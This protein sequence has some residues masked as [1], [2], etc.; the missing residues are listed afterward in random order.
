MLRYTAGTSAAP[1]LCLLRKDIF[2]S[3]AVKLVSA[4]PL[5]SGIQNPYSSQTALW[6]SAPPVPASPSS[7]SPGA[8][9]TDP[10]A[11]PPCLAAFAATSSRLRARREKPRDASVSA[12]DMSPKALRT[13]VAAWAP[14]AACA[15]SS[16]PAPA[17]DASSTPFPAST[18][19]SAPASLSTAPASWSAGPSRPAS[20]VTSP[21][22]SSS[23]I[24]GGAGATF[25]DEIDCPAPTACE[26]A[27]E[28]TAR[29]PL[30][31]RDAPVAGIPTDATA[32]RS[33][34]EGASVG[35]RPRLRPP[36]VSN[37]CSAPG[38]LERPALST[39]ASVAVCCTTC[40][41]APGPAAAL[42]RLRPVSRVATEPASENSP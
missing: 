3:L 21:G 7:P 9:S 40:G 16:A 29:D 20:G 42:N 19:S 35:S 11:L 4:P 28:S 10:S 34:G 6:G 5:T 13:A 27:R 1:S 36:G 37:P 23:G 22:A 18:A 24:P 30:L 15:A 32:L 2:L 39:S 26:A 38:E 17:S 41:A 8:A 33:M 31:G 14:A 12:A 25:L